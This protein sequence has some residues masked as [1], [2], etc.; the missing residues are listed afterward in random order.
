M[1]V[2]KWGEG[3][4]TF[5]KHGLTYEDHH[6]KTAEGSYERSPPSKL[7]SMYDYL[8][9]DPVTSS[10]KH[11]PKKLVIKGD[12]PET[13]TNDL[14]G[15]ARCLGVYDQ[16]PR[17]ANGHPMW[18]HVDEDLV[19]AAGRVDDEDGWVVAQYT[20]FS[21][22]TAKKSMQLPGREAPW[23]NKAGTWQAWGGKE[24]APAPSIKCRPSYHGWGRNGA[25]A[26]TNTESSVSPPR[27]GR[28]PRS[29]GSPTSGA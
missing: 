18:K 28:K 6:F 11:V 22:K 15:Q 2:T 12:S 17:E 27:P 3:G 13:Q 4:D 16:I 9:S 29:P 7:K 10:S 23:T 19:I 21:D 5:S 1:S 8:P 14:N 24:W 26:V 20:T 25:G